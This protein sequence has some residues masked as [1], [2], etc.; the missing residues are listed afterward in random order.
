[1]LRSRKGFLDY[2]GTYTWKH[3]YLLTIHSLTIAW[4]YFKVSMLNWELLDVEHTEEH[5]HMSPTHA[6]AEWPSE[7]RA[8]H[9]QMRNTVQ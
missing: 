8:Q 5:A 6:T 7:L 4:D 9:D 3:L 1:M 2:W